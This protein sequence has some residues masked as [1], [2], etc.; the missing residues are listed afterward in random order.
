MA[1]TRTLNCGMPQSLLVFFISGLFANT[2]PFDVSLNVARGSVKRFLYLVE[3]GQ[4]GDQEDGSSGPMRIPPS[5]DCHQ[6]VVENNAR[7]RSDS[8]H[9]G[10]SRVYCK[11]AIEFA[12]RLSPLYEMYLIHVDSQLP[13]VVDPTKY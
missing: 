9:V 10:V 3:D 13:N 7:P 5:A 11:E 6:L 1:P 2:T 4:R 8:H 12:G